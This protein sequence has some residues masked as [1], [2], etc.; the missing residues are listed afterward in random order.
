MNSF[1]PND[2]AELHWDGKKAMLPLIEGSAGERAVDISKLRDQ[3]GLITLDSGYGNTGSC[4]S[5]ITFIDGEKGI[6]RYRGIPIETLAEQ[7]SFVETAFLIIYGKLP[8]QAELASFSNHLTMHELIHDSSTIGSPS[9]EHW[10]E[11]LRSEIS[12]LFK[13][14]SAIAFT[15]TTIHV[16]RS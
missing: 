14:V 9:G 10:A 3:T 12:W 5:A 6:L 7:S 4:Q 11:I 2:F 13:W 15:R 8:T 16:Q 1:K